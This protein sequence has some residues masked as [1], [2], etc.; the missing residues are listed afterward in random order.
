MIDRFLWDISWEYFLLYIIWYDLKE[1]SFL[2]NN[3]LNFNYHG[4]N[5]KQCG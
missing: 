2:N 1:K 3:L 5:E 4:N